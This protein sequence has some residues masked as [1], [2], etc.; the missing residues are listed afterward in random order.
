MDYVCENYQISK[1]EKTDSTPILAAYG[2]VY[3]EKKAEISGNASKE[4]SRNA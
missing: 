2:K 4:N 1:E 3:A